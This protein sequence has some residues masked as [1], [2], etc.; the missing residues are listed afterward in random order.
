MAVEFDLVSLLHLYLVNIRRV[1]N[2][3]NSIKEKMS[4]SW[5]NMA[6][7]TFL[8]LCFV[9]HLSNGL[10]F[11]IGETERKCFIEEIPD[12][13]MV[14]GKW[15]HRVYRKKSNL[16]VMNWL[17]A[18]IRFNYTTQEPTGSPRKAKASECTWKFE[19]PKTKSFWAK[20]TA[21]KANGRLPHTLQANMSSVCTQTPPNG[22]PELN[23]EFIWT[24]KWVNMPSTM[25]TLP[26]K[27]NYPNCN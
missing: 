19:I 18:I 24:S 27:K 12:E 13:T 2:Q 11:H 22:F 5:R 20:S 14:T 9:I 23:W 17:Q 8:T 25:L 6:L 10:Y 3:K 16:K 26:K 7:A 21:A 1:K 4:N 15:Q